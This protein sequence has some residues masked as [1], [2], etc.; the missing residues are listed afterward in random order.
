MSGLNFNQSYGAVPTGTLQGG[1]VNQLMT[2]GVIDAHFTGPDADVCFWRSKI[3][4]YHNFGIDILSQAFVGNHTWGSENSAPLSKVPDLYLNVFAVI[5]RPGIY[6]VRRAENLGGG[7][8]PRVYSSRPGKTEKRFKLSRFKPRPRPAPTKAFAV[9]EPTKSH[10]EQRASLAK[11]RAGFSG[12]AAK[13]RKGAAQEQAQDTGSEDFWDEQDDE[14][15]EEDLGQDEDSEEL[16]EDGVPRVYAHWVNSLG[17]AAIARAGISLA[18][19]AGQMLT[20][21]WINAWAELTGAPGKEQDDLIGTYGSLKELIEAS[22]RDERIYVHL[23]FGWT[24]YSGRCLSQV[25]MRFHTISCS[26]ALRPLHKLIQI[27][28][29]DVEVLKTSDGLPIGKTDVAVHLDTTAVFLDLAERKMFARAEFSMLWEQLEY[30]EAT[31]QGTSLRCPLSFTKP[32]RMIVISVQRKELEDANKTFDYSSPIPNEDP[33]SFITLNVG[34]STRYAREGQHSRKVVPFEF[35]PRTLKRG[36]YLYPIVFCSDPTPEQVNGA[37]NF[38]RNE[39]NS[40]NLELAPSMANSV[41][42]VRIENYAIN[43]ATFKKGLVNIE[44]N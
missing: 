39:N 24:R 43:L 37:L 15:D 36:R 26:L 6:G 23:P 12:A 41:N 17:H 32:S 3:R 1:A 27:S 30:Y 16:D 2:A 34:S 13:R 8:G 42:T 18:G 25:T 9:T 4:K 33:V 44:Y 40:V 31:H 22:G 35:L 7:S 14:D 20:G 29:P 38:G 28:H 10:G 5:D 21:R 19:Q 11:K